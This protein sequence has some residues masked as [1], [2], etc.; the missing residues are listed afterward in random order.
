MVMVV[1]LVVIVDLWS[2]QARNCGGTCA[3]QLLPVPLRSPDPDVPLDV[4]QALDTIY[5]EAQYGLTLNYDGPPPPPSLSSQDM[6]W[7]ES[8]VRSLRHAGS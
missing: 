3:R 8:C 6:D 7:V 5:D 1:V 4:Q 2:G